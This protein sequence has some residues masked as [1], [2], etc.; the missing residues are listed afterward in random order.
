MKDVRGCEYSRG[1]GPGYKEQ[2]GARSTMCQFQ[3]SRREQV[4]LGFF[5]RGRRIS[6]PGV[7]TTIG[8]E[9]RTGIDKKSVI[10]SQHKKPIFFFS[11]IFISPAYL[12]GLMS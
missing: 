1:P 11:F 9:F 10:Q 6:I 8:V 2:E 4:G 7:G 5:Q 12:P 3:E